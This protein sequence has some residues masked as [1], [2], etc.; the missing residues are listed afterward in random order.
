MDAETREEYWVSGV[1]QRGSNT[2]WAEHVAI[3]IDP[4]ALDA[5]RELRS[6]AQGTV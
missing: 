3:E 1:K 2:H 6:S 4:D 5:Y